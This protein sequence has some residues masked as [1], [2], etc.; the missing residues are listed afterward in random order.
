MGIRSAQ[1]VL[2]GDGH[3]VH[4]HS[5][6]AS[7]ADQQICLQSEARL[8][9]GLHASHFS[10]PS[11]DAPSLS[12]LHLASLPC[13]A[14]ACVGPVQCQ[15]KQSLVHTQAQKDEGGTTARSALTSRCMTRKLT[16]GCLIRKSASTAQ[17]CAER[18]MRSAIVRRP[19][20][21]SQQSKGASPAP[22]AF[23]VCHGHRAGGSSGGREGGGEKGMHAIRCK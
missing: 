2:M 11:S 16:S 6:V 17:L 10:F 8:T 15:P 18:S 7:T 12:S 5:L 13:P 23:C 14:V 9:Q 3:A 1:R 4:Q 22:S 20:R 21:A 19:R